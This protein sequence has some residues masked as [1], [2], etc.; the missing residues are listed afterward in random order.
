MALVSMVSKHKDYYSIPYNI[1]SA[2][3]KRDK[4]R[5]LADLHSNE[6]LTVTNGCFLRLVNRLNQGSLCSRPTQ[7]IEQ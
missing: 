3:L 4:C 1:F 7:K 5:R 6:W 2:S